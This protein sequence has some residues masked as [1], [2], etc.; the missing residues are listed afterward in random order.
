MVDKGFMPL[1][2]DIKDSPCVVVGA[3]PI[4]YRKISKLL[5][6]GAKVKVIAPVITGEPIRELID[7]GKVEYI[8]EN[9]ACDEAIESHLKGSFLVVAATDN[10]DLNEALYSYCKA[11]H[12]IINNITSPKQCNSRFAAEINEQDLQIAVS[13][14]GKNPSLA[15]KIRDKIKEYIKKE[16]DV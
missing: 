13:T 7:Q 12:I 16:L 8:E 5:S 2:I 1:F 11:H 9:I 6:Y 10:K 3:G 14:K 15:V 4:A